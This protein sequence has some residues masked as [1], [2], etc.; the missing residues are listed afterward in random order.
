MS[1]LKDCP[2]LLQDLL[3]KVFVDVC[4]GCHVRI[5]NCYEISNILFLIITS[6]Y[7]VCSSG[8]NKRCVLGYVVV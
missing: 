6:L 1:V 4:Q 8:I 5:A 2:S 7:F 3:Y